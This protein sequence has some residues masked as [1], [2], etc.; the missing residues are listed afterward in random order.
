MTIDCEAMMNYGI[1]STVNKR[2]DVWAGVSTFFMVGAWTDDHFSFFLFFLKKEKVMDPKEPSMVGN[3]KIS[4]IKRHQLPNLSPSS[5]SIAELWTQKQT[6][7]WESTM[8][9]QDLLHNYLCLDI[10]RAITYK[11]YLSSIYLY[12]YIYWGSRD[13]LPQWLQALWYI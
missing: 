5:C 4:L 12:I 1:P 13:Q 7:F 10:E 11:I 3:M 6:Q 2:R 8:V 9:A